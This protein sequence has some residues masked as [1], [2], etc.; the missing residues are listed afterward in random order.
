MKALILTYDPQIGLADLVVRSYRKLLGRDLFEFRVPV[1][2]EAARSRIGHFHCIRF[3]DTASG[4][5]STMSALLDDVADDEW[6]YWAID[7]RY[8]V[9]IDVEAFVR[10]HDAIQ[11]GALDHANGIK[12]LRWREELTEQDLQ[13]SAGLFRRQKMCGMFG[14][15]HHHFV[16]GRVLKAVFLDEDAAR[17]TNIRDLNTYHHLGA[18]LPCFDRVFVPWPDNLMHLGEPLINDRL[19]A[20]GLQALREHGCNVPAY[21][22]LARTVHFFD[23]ERQLAANPT[24][25][26]QAAPQ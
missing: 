14:F 6:V 23:Y 7:D 3:V 2:S 26:R 22:V 13:T 10:L 25:P 24:D 1:N 11:S 12:L 18:S 8:P 16:K 15:W 4:I 17:I 21:E 5:H 20:N 19:T 9:K